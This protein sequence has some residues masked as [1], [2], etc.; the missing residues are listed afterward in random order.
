MKLIEKIKVNRY[1]HN[2]DY[3]SIKKEL[4]TNSKELLEILTKEQIIELIEYIKKDDINNLF[5]FFDIV[6]KE[7]RKYLIRSCYANEKEIPYHKEFETYFKDFLEYGI[8]T[9]NTSLLY[10]LAYITIIKPETHKDE[11]SLLK[12]YFLD[13]QVDEKF[14]MLAKYDVFSC[15]EYENKIL[16]SNALYV[17]Q[18]IKSINID[19]SKKILSK[20]LLQDIN[21]GDIKILASELKNS[22]E[23]YEELVNNIKKIDN[24]EKIEYLYIILLINSD[25]QNTKEIINIIINSKKITTIKKLISFINEEEQ[26]NLIKE[27]IEKNNKK[28]IFNLACTTDC[29][30]TYKAIEYILKEDNFDQI[31]YMISSIEGRFLDYTLNKIITDKEKDFYIKIINNLYILSLPN[32]FETINF[33]FIYK[34]EYLFKEEIINNLK[35]FLIKKDNKKTLKLILK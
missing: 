32:F 7:Q 27:N 28:V 19:Q 29:L 2:K 12:D 35:R 30:N 17:A 1:F 6:N 21:I 23:L 8:E 14:V 11:I 33:I 13:E 18:Y 15:D 34:L 25:Y 10:H 3:K 9:D 22:N 5:K 4:I 16:Q 31:L 26:N 24:E 20:Y